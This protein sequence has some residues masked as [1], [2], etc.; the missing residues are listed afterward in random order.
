[1]GRLH[2]GRHFHGPKKVVRRRAGG[3]AL[4]LESAAQNEGLSARCRQEAP[5][6][7]ENKSLASYWASLLPSSIC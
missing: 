3:V 7:E 1:M 6:L 2:Q 5:M 4:G